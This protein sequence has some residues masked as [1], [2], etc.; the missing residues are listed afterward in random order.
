MTMPLNPYVAGNPV[1][2]SP[3]FVGRADVLRKVLR[4]LRRSQDNAIVLYGQRRI[5]KTSILQHLAAW[6]PR[7]GTYRPVYFDLQDKAAWP[8]DRV[9][10]ELARTI[11]HALGQPDLDGST[12]LAEVLGPDPETAFRDEWLPAI[13]DDLPERASLV[14]LFDEFDVLDTPE[15]E[16]AAAFF[17]YLRGLLASNPRQLQSIF[18][19]DRNVNDLTNIAFSLFKG[20]PYQRVSLLD[21]EDTADLVRLSE[22][23]KTLRWPNEAVKRAWQLTCGHP[24]LTQ[25]LCSHVW[26]RAYDEEPEEPPTVTPEAVD[27]AV[28]DALGASRNTLEW[29]WNGLPPAERVV[30]SALAE[31]GPSP[32]THGKLERLLRESGVRVVI[33]ELQNA[34]QILQE[35][36]ILEPADGGYRFRVELLRRWIVEHKPLRRVQE[37]PDHIHEGI[38]VTAAVRGLRRARRREVKVSTSNPFFYGNP[39]PPDQFIDRQRTLRRIASRIVNQGQST[40]IVGEPL[41]GK[42]SLLLYLAAPET[43]TKLYSAGGERLLFS[44][45]DARTLGDEF[46]QAQ[47][48][49]YA[50]R[51]LHE[52]VIAPNPDSPLA[53]AYQTCRENDFG[54]FV[55]ERLLAGVKA[56]RWQLVL[57]LDEFNDLLH[58]PTLNCAKFVGSLRGLASRSRGALA[59]VIASR[60]SLASL[61]EA[62]QQFSRTGSPYFNFLTEVTLGPLPNR[63]IAELLHRAVDR[64]T[65]DDRRFIVEVAGGHPYLVQVAAATLWRA[66]EDGESDSNARRQQ[67]GRHLY[68]EAALTLSHTWQ[69]W[70]PA[71]QRAFAAV[72]LAHMH[73][74]GQRKSNVRR[75]I[76][77]MRD[78]GPELRSLK[79]RGF[80]AE[81]ESIPGGWRVCPQAFLWWLADELVRTVRDETPF[82]EWLQKQE[83][84]GLLTR[85]EKEQLGKALHAV[86]SL[87]KNGA[88]TLIEAAAKGAGQ[89]M[90]KGI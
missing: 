19:I 90:V 17:P 15:A 85:G 61:N 69:L 68:D 67:A 42:T 84:G 28:P 82:E 60:R 4:V 14:L 18:V 52:Q 10:R 6:L 2:D 88:A 36:D 22:A 29:L 16:Q 51:P 71:R 89:A 76:G 50:L 55:L 54:C 44:Y 34:P 40:A 39:V 5:G 66:Y 79:K 80:V 32:I 63:A 3:A 78:L 49:E 86:G 75:L 43:R 73:A 27:A 70:S 12:E 57:L 26:E 25:Q 64:F 53:K 87:L 72:A 13:L 37:E 7:E 62:T 11:A 58:H 35:W 48:W 38:E 59:L 77:D 30:I 83:L 23:N 20:T 21:R 24:F 56:E 33:R 9:L 65:R 1:G 81:D 46:G 31:A 41:S 45:L 8:L 47:F 74:L